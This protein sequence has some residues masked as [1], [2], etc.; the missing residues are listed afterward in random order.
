MNHELLDGVPLLH[1]VRSGPTSVNLSFRVGQSDEKLAQRGLTHLVEHLALFPLGIRDHHANGQT[2]LSITNFQASGDADDVV[3]FLAQVT[4]ALSDLPLHRLKD[5][6]SVLQTEA[7]QRPGWVASDLALWR[8]GARGDGAAAYPEWGLDKADEASVEA[9]RDHW[10][11]ADNAVLVV[12]GPKVPPGL[13]L[14]LPSGS[15][16]AMAPVHSLLPPGRSTISVGSNRVLF[17]A[18]VERT[19]ATTVLAQ[20]VD[21]MM[22]QRLRLDAG[23]SYVATCNYEPR[24]ATWAVMTGLADALEDKTDVLVGASVD[25]LAELRLGRLPDE[26]V[27]KVIAGRLDAMENPA[28][29]DDVSTLR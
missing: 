20:L 22:F 1:A 2:G 16:R 14:H 11:T 23:Y 9:W 21:Q 28:N 25:L 12:V 27:E 17:D 29:A 19:P 4:R 15:R 24:D 13:R 6:R 10:F 18:V 3:T 8:Y 5:E 7:S 26:A